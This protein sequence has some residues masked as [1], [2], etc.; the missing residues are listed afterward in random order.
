M[1]SSGR[2]AVVTG[3]NRGLG[4]ETCRRLGELGDRV[5]L[6]SRSLARARQAAALLREQG[7]DVVG[8]EVDVR[9]D[10]SVADFFADYDRRHG[11]IDVLVN[12]AG[13]VFGGEGGGATKAVDTPS[14]VL[15]AAFDN[16]AIGA[17]RMLRGALPRM[18]G[19]GYGRV[20]NVSSGM[21][22]IA[23]MD[24]GHA[25]YRLSKA[26]LNAITRLFHAEAKRNVLVN[27]VCPG[28]VRTDMG[29]QS[30]TRS[31]E[32]GASGIVWAATLPEG[33]PSGGFFRDGE[34]TPW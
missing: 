7:L 9:S 18:N 23:E 13:A 16:N 22:G 24:G 19:A 25:A 12:N 20:V 26:A 28:W 5:V 15:I 11:R 33:G 4:L 31:V 3:G 1:K 29:G 34:P 32:E 30:A 14:E 21:G 10:D 6:T 8:E 27:S 2:V 17:F